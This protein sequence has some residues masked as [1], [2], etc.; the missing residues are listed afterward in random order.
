MKYSVWEEGDVTPSY[1]SS[2]SASRAASGSVESPANSPYA[3]AVGAADVGADGVARGTLEPFSSR[4]P[5][6]DGRVKPDITGWDGVSSPVYGVTTSSSGGFYGTSAAAPHVAGAAALVKQAN[7][8][9]DAAQL[10]YLLEQRAEQWQRRTIRRSTR[11]GTGCSRSAHRADVSAPP[12]SRYTAITPKRLLDTRTTTGGH[13]ARVGAG[14]AVTLTVPGLPADA[15]AVAIN[16]TGISAS[17]TTYLS[18]YRG[19]TTF[20]GTSNLN[21]STNDPTAAVFAIVSVGPAHTITLRNANGTVD[22]AADEVGYFGTAATT[23]AYTALAAPRRVLDT[24]TTT[25]GHHGKVANHATVSV[26]PSLPASATA[27]VVNLTV[28][29][30]TA[31]G[32]LTA[33][34][35]CTA[36]CRR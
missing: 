9:L 20:A 25:G 24:R 31:S 35:S 34:P 2:L 15:T 16:L 27:A 30:N 13:H 36:R 32:Y 12:G 1:L 26:H 10:Q 33:A 14:G 6:I 28:T 3:L 17:G 4:G 5:T 7:P 21:L 19:G 18:A 29:G 11:S 8:Q 22:I 23:G